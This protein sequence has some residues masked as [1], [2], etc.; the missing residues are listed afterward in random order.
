MT[1]GS[2]IPSTNISLNKIR[3][4]QE[5][6]VLQQLDEGSLTTC[7][8]RLLATRPYTGSTNVELDNATPHA[9]SEFAGYKA[10]WPEISSSTNYNKINLLNIDTS[11]N[12]FV[13]SSVKFE[14]SMART[15]VNN[16]DTIS[17][18]ADHKLGDYMGVAKDNGSYTNVTSLGD[19]KLGEVEYLNSTSRP[20]S[21]YIKMVNGNWG[22]GFPLNHYTTYSNGTQSYSMNPPN[23]L[24]TFYSNPL[25]YF[26]TGFDYQTIANDECGSFAIDRTSTFDVIFRKSGFADRS[27]FSFTLYEEV[28]GIW[29][30]GFCN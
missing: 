21:Y 7:S 22:G 19:I 12:N 26:P 4:T 10:P 8:T 5:Y 3:S 20:D 2:T 29:T 15:S 13:F 14:F 27:V 17:F 24:Y 1:T 23:T 16:V 18:Y 25:Y 11:S 6:E 30:G 28:E 9:M